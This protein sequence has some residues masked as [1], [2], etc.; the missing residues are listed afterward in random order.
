MALLSFSGIL[1]FWFVLSVSLRAL[2]AHPVHPGC[3]MKKILELLQQELKVLNVST[4][5][6]ENVFFFS[7]MHHYLLD[8]EVDSLRLSILE[9]FERLG[10]EIAFQSS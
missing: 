3:K 9:K 10:K 4:E 6:F 8:S 7:K 5:I 2:T 1:T